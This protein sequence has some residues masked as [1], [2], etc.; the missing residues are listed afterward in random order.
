MKRT[1]LL[2]IILLI[3]LCSGCRSKDPFNSYDI[4]FSELGNSEISTIKEIES[5]L[6]S[7]TDATI[8][9]G[10]KLVHFSNTVKCGNKAEIVMCGKPDTEYTIRV[11]YSSGL[12]KAKSLKPQSSDKDG[13]VA[14]IWTVGA[15][16]KAGSYPVEILENGATVLKTQLLVL[17]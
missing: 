16:T 6:T 7:T 11:T 13:Y 5:E 15:K 8:Y 14:W 10:A 1:Y 4:K 2:L 17:Q 9:G 3:L 12:S